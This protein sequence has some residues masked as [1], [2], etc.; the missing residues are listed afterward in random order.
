MKSTRQK[1]SIRLEYLVI[2]IAAVVVAASVY[3]L[4]K[5]NKLSVQH[6]AVDRDWLQV[7]ELAGQASLLKSKIQPDASARTV[8]I[9]AHVQELAAQ[10]FGDKARVQMSGELI[11]INLNQVTPSVFAQALELLRT[12]TKAHF[13]SA[14]I[15]SVNGN[16]SGSLELRLPMER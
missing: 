13:I 6:A 14:N 2:L 16:L 15:N 11:S 3:P 1:L 7:Q 5:L 9:G 10:Q 4:Q 12:E 8:N